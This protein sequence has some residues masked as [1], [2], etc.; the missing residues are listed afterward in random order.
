MR[1]SGEREE[2]PA[3]APRFLFWRA[4]AAFLALPGIVA[5]LGPWLM[6]PTGTPF[7]AIGFAPLAVGIVLL[8]W[9]VRDFYVVGK[10]TL[11]PWTPPA[12]LVIVGLYR[13]TRNPMYVAVILIL[14]GWALGFA[15]RDLWIYAGIV[16]VLFHL[17]VV[18]MEE[19]WLTRRHGEAYM[20]YKAKVPRWLV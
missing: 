10:G 5:F 14:C 8:L 7:R 1:V 15:S 4:L 2:V 17:R 20:A 9:C 12:R 13:V 18:L 16:A 6:R 11:A 3:S 19:P